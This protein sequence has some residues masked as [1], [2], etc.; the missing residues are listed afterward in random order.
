[1][2]MMRTHLQ[3]RCLLPVI[4]KQSV[5]VAVL[6]PCLISAS[7][8][9]PSDLSW[10]LLWGDSDDGVVCAVMSNIKQLFKVLLLG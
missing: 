5:D 10:M 3:A 4:V 6:A 7:C 1:M 2:V 9:P 8:D